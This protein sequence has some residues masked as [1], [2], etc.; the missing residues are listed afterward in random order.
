MNAALTGVFVLGWRQALG[1]V[2]IATGLLAAVLG[3]GTWRLRQP[4]LVP[5]VRVAVMQPSIEQPLKWDPRHARET[6]AIYLALTRLAAAGGA[7]LI[8]W[9]ETASPTV[10]RR[11][12]ELQRTLT[13]LSAELRAP[14]LVGSIDVLDG[15]PPAPQQRRVPRQRPGDRRQV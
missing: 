1:G 2:V 11:D 14:L 8:V 13:D 10:L 12:A 3:F 9:P 4:P 6:L 15:V 5:E 7:E